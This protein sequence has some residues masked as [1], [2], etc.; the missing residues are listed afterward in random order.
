MKYIW[1]KSEDKFCTSQF[2]VT[3]NAEKE[4]ALN[5]GYIEITDEDYEKIVRHE[6][7]WE[8]DVLVPYTKTQVEQ[9]Q[10]ALQEKLMRIEELKQLLVSWD[11][12]TSKYADGEYTNEEWSKIVAQ[13]KAWREEINRLEAELALYV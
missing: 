8:N 1:N 3:N 2:I 11:Y 4:I 12:K 7:C 13:R 6:M 5:A 10:D 9:N